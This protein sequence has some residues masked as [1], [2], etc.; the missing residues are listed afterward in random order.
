MISDRDL[1]LCANCAHMRRL[2]P[3]TIDGTPEDDL[4]AYCDRTKHETKG[5]VKCRLFRERRVNNERM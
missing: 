5:Y 3:T 2:R 4:I 1:G